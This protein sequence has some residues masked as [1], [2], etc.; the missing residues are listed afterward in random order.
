MSF[1]SKWSRLAI[2]F[3]AITLCCLMF[4]GAALAETSFKIYGGDN[5]ATGNLTN[6]VKASHT[7]DY[8]IDVQELTVDVSSFCAN[9]IEVTFPTVGSGAAADQFDLTQ[10]IGKSV[11]VEV[12]VNGSGPYY[13]MTIPEIDNNAHKATFE[14]QKQNVPTVSGTV[15][16]FTISGLRVKNTH[17]PGSYCIELKHKCFSSG[18]LNLEVV[19]TVGSIKITAP[20]TCTNIVGGTTFEVKG[21][22]CGT[23]YI[24]WD[25]TSWP[26][27][28]E[29]TDKK[30]RPVYDPNQGIRVTD[31][32]TGKDVFI[33]PCSSTTQIGPV[34]ASTDGTGKFT[35]SLR[36]PACLYDWEGNKCNDFVVT[37]RTMEVADNTPDSGISYTEPIVTEVPAE[38]IEDED[39]VTDPITNCT[40]IYRNVYPPASSP[41]AYLA[42][43]GQTIHSVPGL[44]NNILQTKPGNNREIIVNKPVDVTVIAIDKFGRE[45]SVGSQPLKIDLYAFV[46]GYPSQLA[47]KFYDKPSRE[48]GKEITETYI[49]QG[50]S[51]I[52]VTFEPSVTGTIVIE[53][54]ANIA[55]EP[56]VAQCCNINV[57]K[58]SSCFLEVKPVVTEWCNETNPRAGWPL[59]GAI[60]LDQAASEDYDVIVKLTDPG[61]ESP[62]NFAEWATWDTALN[63]CYNNTGSNKGYADKDPVTGELVCETC[64]LDWDI[65]THPYCTNKSHFYI[66][67]SP[68]AEGKEL[69]VT[70]YLRSKQSGKVVMECSQTIGPFASPVELKRSL[71]C[72]T[73]QVLS[74]PKWLAKQCTPGAHGTFKDLLPE[75]S[76]AKIVCWNDEYKTWDVVPDT[77]PVE[78]LKAYF[79]RTNQ[80]QNRKGWEADY[81]FA[82]ATEP[83]AMQP[84]VRTLYRGW[85]TFGI[86][87]ND[88]VDN[89]G[90]GDIP[91]AFKQEDF[92]YRAL[93]SVCRGCKVVWNP[94]K[95]GNLSQWLTDTVSEGTQGAWFDDPYADIYNGDGYWIYMTDRQDLAANVGLDLVDP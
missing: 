32:C 87:V 23:C 72:D 17:I 83:G 41:H 79:V 68:D 21:E 11:Q 71:A 89:D 54:R 58:E 20:V 92:I 56:K 9:K 86:A 14:I 78:P 80:C 5:P 10:A 45:T 18:C 15:I 48:G 37:A 3:T 88:R 70:V 6:V 77:S 85:N 65:Y 73:W 40:H 31:P 84:H 51:S 74:T 50:G 52:T 94:H 63:V 44:L 62:C 53:E 93:G 30:G 66:Y 46:S 59:K 55:G 7:Y 69:M 8:I 49:P 75:G 25:K 82:R 38:G 19:Q 29:I 35:A 26:V 95:L 1:S 43:C 76:V 28:I 33:D 27:I 39:G 81:I 4:T 60:I 22:I 90:N 91:D 34:V 57:I 67:V 24:P 64:H 36:M 12:R 2:V 16:G 13:L 47:G 42:A 61:S